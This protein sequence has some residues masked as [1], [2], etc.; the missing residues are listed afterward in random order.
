VITSESGPIE[1]RL[2]DEGLHLGPLTVSFQRFQQPADG[3]VREVPHSLGALPLGEGDAGEWLLPVADD[4]AFWI[5]LNAQ[6]PIEVAIEVGTI[7]GRSLDAL[8]GLAWDARAPHTVS[9]NSFAIVAGIRRDDDSLWAFTPVPIEDV[10][11][12]CDAI[13]FFARNRHLW[14]LAHVRLVN[15]SN[16][17][18]RTGRSPP[19]P[20]DPNSGYSGFRLP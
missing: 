3:T 13:R 7:A 5:G 6:R 20:I 17:A 19:T 8:S 1:R 12:A 18:A 15:Y 10:A 2:T 14:Q 11:P 9:P 4:E 16:F